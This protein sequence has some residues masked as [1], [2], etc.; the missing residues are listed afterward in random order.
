MVHARVLLVTDSAGQM[1][2]AVTIAVRYSVVRRQAA[3]RKG[4]AITIV[5]FSDPLPTTLPPGNWRLR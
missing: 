4:Y 5:H 3:Q 1:A 2:K